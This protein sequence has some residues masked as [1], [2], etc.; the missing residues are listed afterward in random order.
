LTQ[1]KFIPLHTPLGTA[2]YNLVDILPWKGFYTGPIDALVSD[3]KELIKNLKWTTF[4]NRKHALIA[5]SPKKYT[6][7]PS[8]PLLSAHEP[9]RI[10]QFH[11]TISSILKSIPQE[12][13]NLLPPFNGATITSYTQGQY[14]PIHRDNEP[15]RSHTIL[16]LSIGDK[17]HFN[18]GGMWYPLETGTI[19]A[20]NGKTP[21][22]TKPLK[23][24][25][26]INFTF[27][28]FI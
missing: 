20:F 11:K 15:H 8:N 19:L 7:D 13:R 22:Y 27:R 24:K 4:R 10:I 23:G 1:L 18:L 26:R 2:P 6:W 5:T 25:V 9:A 21:H 3:L 16:S 28:C 17:V 14:I 12:I